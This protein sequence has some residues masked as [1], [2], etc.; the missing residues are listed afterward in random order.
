MENKSG[1]KIT[2]LEDQIQKVIVMLEE[3]NHHNPNSMVELL[4]KRYRNA[5]DIVEKSK[6]L[7]E[8]SPS[9]FHIIGG[10]RAYIDSSSNYD[11]PVLEEMHK[12]EQLVKKI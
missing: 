7:S 10:T 2:E 8:L 9:D 6:D 11:N 3:E 1:N 5:F 4:I 12:T